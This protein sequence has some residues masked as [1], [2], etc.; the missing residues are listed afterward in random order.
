MAN[1]T[2]IAELNTLLR[3]TTT[4]IIIAETRRAQAGSEAIERELARNAY[5]GRERVQLIKAAIRELGGLPD[6]VGVAAGR[7]GAFAK[8]QIE[9][10]Q[11]L[12]N[13]LLGDL[14]LEQQLYARARFLRVLA[15][16]SEETKVVRVAER[17]ERAHAETIEWLE[18]RLAEV[19][20][21]GPPAIRPTPVQAA[22]GFA[23]RLAAFP[24][25]GAA[26][27]INQ[28]IRT[29]SSF[30][31]AAGELLDEQLEKVDDLKEAAQEVYVAGRNASLKRAETEAREE[32]ASR[33]A[34]A[35]HS[36]RGSLGVLDSAE[37][38]ISDYDELNAT[39]ATQLIKELDDAKDVRAILAYEQRNAARQSV[40]N[41]AQARL[42]A[43]ARDTLDDE[44]S[45]SAQ[46]SG[47]S[48]SNASTTAKRTKSPSSSKRRA[49]RLG[50]LTVKELRAKAT[51]ANLQGR[52][53]M[54]KNELVDALAQS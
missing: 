11:D 3:M 39:A 4:E 44:A 20:L 45:T 46:A 36:T 16:T 50:E 25:R 5:K 29:I 23:R 43:L 33:T 7:V 30:R 40:I 12:A 52:S 1:A 27:S 38:P 28:T 51:K 35:I 17:L 48:G 14:A 2:L 6:A 47:T 42:G 41:T 31:S 26:T 10:G 54:T 18:I 53:G 22:A 49:E 9:Q 32:G 37:L 34:H 8:S 13:A 19:A 24:L 15:K 21:G